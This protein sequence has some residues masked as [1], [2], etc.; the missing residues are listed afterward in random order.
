MAPRLILCGLVMALA[1]PAM[2]VG[3]AAAPATAQAL[4][5]ESGIRGGLCVFL[6][7]GDRALASNLV[8]RGPFV[9]QWL[10]P[11]SP[12]TASLRDSLRAVN[13]YG[14]VSVEEW[15]DRT[16]PYADNLV[17]A[18]LAWSPDAVP[19]DELLRVLR[20]GGA[21][22]ILQN[23]TWQRRIK[24]RPEGMDEW[25]HWRHGPDRNPV[26]EDR[27]V[28]VPGRIQWLSFH[29]VEGK[30]M[31]TANGRNFYAYQGMI[32]ARDA[33]NGIPLWTRKID[34]RGSPVAV[35]DRV[36]VATRDRIVCL[37][38]SSGRPMLTYEGSPAAANALMVVPDP[39]DPAGVL[40]A[41]NTDTVCAFAATSGALLWKHPEVNPRALSSRDGDLY[42]VTGGIET[43]AV[44]TVSCLAVADGKARWLQHNLP[45]ARVCF[46]S[47][48]DNGV[49]AFETGKFA[50]PRESM[51]AAG[52][53]G[54]NTVHFVSAKDGKL[55]RNYEFP[56]AMR[57]DENPRTFFIGKTIAVNRM[58]KDRRSSSLAVFAT[59]EAEPTLFPALPHGSQYF[60]CYPPTATERFFIYGQLNFT[61]WA[62]HAQTGNPITRGTCG[63]WSEGVIPANGLIYVFPKSCNCYSMLHGFGG[64]APSYKHAIP[65]D[66]PLTK[67]PA[68][69]APVPSS[70]RPDD[71]P[72]LRGDE[73]RSGSTVD[74]GP[75]RFD[76]L[77][78]A[79]I[80]AALC[81]APLSDEWQQY[82]FSA[83][84]LSPPVIAEGKVFVVQPHAQ[85]LVALRA[86]DGKPAWDFTA[87]GRIDTPPTISAGLCLFGTRLGTVYALRA[88]DGALVWSRRLA[89]AELRIVHCGQ[90]ES[91]WP[92]QGS[93]LVSG[94]TAYV[95][96]GI[97]PLADGGIRVFALDPATG[98]IR[99]H[100]VVTD[101]GYDTNGWHSRAGL[102]QD[103]FDL[104]V[105][106]GDKVALSHW[107]FDPKTGANE[108]QWHN[109]FYRL[110]TDGAYM[111][112][113]SWSYGYPMNRPRMKRPLVV[114]RGATVFGANKA[115]DA[116]PGNLKLFRRDFAPGEKFET[117]WDEKMNDTDSR[118]GIYFP[119]NRL[120]EKT[121]WSAPYPG[122]IEALVLAKDRLLL[123]SK[124]KL[125]TYATQ[126]GKVLAETELEQ[127]VWDGL[128]VAGGRLYVSTRSS[129]VLCLGTR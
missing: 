10:V 100:Q 77:W 49:V 11:A 91:P 112:R 99:W 74:A 126:D 106:D 4:L 117:A 8:T 114:G 2:Q 56:P 42:M 116:L 75:E 76:T 118:I 36:F 58:D 9:V 1:G 92:A 31:V 55:I 44:A 71:W 64:L 108:F 38:A 53:A 3:A 68:F 124:G 14:A 40:L 35:G 115:S 18:L 22:L 87:N 110:G 12:G 102:E 65:D 94:G 51:T 95:G 113:G 96:V 43:G 46:R 32:V 37:Q 57:H 62:T 33:F 97:H 5:D 121:T 7:A 85:R 45:W 34:S 88:S 25:T 28:E 39:R 111:Q 90:V 79:P 61:D 93:V 50:V 66:Y 84:P 101:M 41:A 17:S 23:G 103:Y 69:G 125:R 120:A 27:L 89:P 119:V 24:P 26:S 129:Q 21:L 20:P 60:Y 29:G 72:C 6:G 105:R 59:P 78:T 81:S 82:P 47:C 107:I 104:M 30:D 19:A 127:P 63:S 80:P 15:S 86:T 109:A 128:A 48:C 54:D 67:G 52:K 98:D 16:L 122:W 70:V 73:Y 83:G 13:L 123:F